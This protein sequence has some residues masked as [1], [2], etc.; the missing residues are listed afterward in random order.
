MYVTNK[1]WENKN[2]CPSS[3]ISL[4]SQA[5]LCP[6][7]M[8]GVPSA[9]TVIYL[10]EVI[11]V[12]VERP[13]ICMI[14]VQC[15]LVEKK[16]MGEKKCHEC[17]RRE[18]MENGIN[19]SSTR[20]AASSDRHHTL[21]LLRH[22]DDLELQGIAKD[23]N[24]YTLKSTHAFGALFHLVLYTAFDSSDFREGSLTSYA[25]HNEL[26]GLVKKLMTT[27]K[28]HTRMYI[29]RCTILLY[30]CIFIDSPE[31]YKDFRFLYL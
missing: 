15:L 29:D 30:I 2:L 9:P 25:G 10:E 17:L 22:G 11:D 26:L 20:A 5:N 31:G 3:R 14:S 7:Q 8:M 19:S 16:V 13:C 27:K 18:N 24:K 1:V 28:I 6:T 23:G 21:P 4:E 12:Q